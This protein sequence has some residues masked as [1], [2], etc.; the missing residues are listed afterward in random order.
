MGTETEVPTPA[1]VVRAA[2]GVKKFLTGRLNRLSS[3]FQKEK[4]D[5]EKQVYSTETDQKHA[6]SWED[7]K[8]GRWIRHHRAPRRDPFTPSGAPD[9]PP[10]ADLEETRVTERDFQ[11]GQAT[12]S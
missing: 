12:D 3:I 10:L 6:D 4:P 8:D 7:R 9:G 2:S 11:M 1:R 5:D